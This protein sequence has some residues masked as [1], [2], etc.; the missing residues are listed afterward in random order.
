VGDLTG[1]GM[2]STEILDFALQRGVVLLFQGPIYEIH[3]LHALSQQQLVFG[4]NGGMVLP[5]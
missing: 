4:G 1:F 3:E 5:N 2:V